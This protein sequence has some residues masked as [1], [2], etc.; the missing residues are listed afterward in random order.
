M[1]PVTSTLQMELA[2]EINRKKVS[3]S[4]KRLMDIIGSM[5]GLILCLPLILIIALAIKLTS[6][7]AR[8]CSGR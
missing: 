5:V 7:R 1:G 8:C 3:L 2:R 6:K 4:A